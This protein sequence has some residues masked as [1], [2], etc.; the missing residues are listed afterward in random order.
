[1]GMMNERSEAF[2]QAYLATTPDAEERAARFYET[3][4]VGDTAEDA[5][6]GA[7]LIMEGAKTTTSGLLWGYEITGD[8]PPFV[9]ALGVVEN[10]RSEPVCV[11]ETTRLEAIPLNA[12]TDVDFIVRYGEWGVTPESWQER[13]WAYYAPHCR[14][15]GREPQPDMPMLCEWFQVVY[16]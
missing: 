8:P 9:G 2:W 13:A 4:Q 1:M 12:V 5:D 3:Y 15:L 14:E 6:Y 16:P 10:G 7:R 11:V